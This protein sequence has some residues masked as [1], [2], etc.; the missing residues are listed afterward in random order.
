MDPLGYGNQGESSRYA[1]SQ[2]TMS[3]TQFDDMDIQT[4]SMEEE[5]EMHAF[6][7]VE[8]AMYNR[9]IVISDGNKDI[10]FITTA[11]QKITVMMMKLAVAV[12]CCLLV[13]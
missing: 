12:I 3:S 2:G 13:A 10:D 1:D 9:G 11:M 8:P 4:L 7:P 5:E 6:R